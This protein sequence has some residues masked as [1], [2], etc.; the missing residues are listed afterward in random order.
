MRYLAETS[1]WAWGASRQR[2]DI[3]QKLAAR[4]G[5]DLVTVCVPVA[6]EVM[7]R[8]DSSARYAEQ[9]EATFA[10]LEWL[11][12]TRAASERAMEVQRLLAARSDGAQRRS[13][14]DFLVAAVAEQH[15]D[16]VLWC[17]DKDFRVI[18]D[19][20][21]QPIEEESPSAAA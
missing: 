13:P 9:F 11:P 18:A 21:G 4:I 5:Q 19:I 17:F 3:R 14:V 6:L 8:A 2:P 10:K 15:D 12:V 1:I 20:T 16:V 7:H